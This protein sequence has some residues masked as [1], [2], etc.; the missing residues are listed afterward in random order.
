MID[1]LPN[2]KLN[3]GDLDDTLGSIALKMISQDKQV[4]LWLVIGYTVVI[5]LAILG[6]CVLNHVIM[7][8]KRVHIITGLFIVNVSV[9]KMMLALLSHDKPTMVKGELKLRKATFSNCRVCYLC[10]SL[11]F[12][13]MTGHFSRFS[14]YSCAYG[15]VMTMA[16][17]SLNIRNIT[18]ETVY[19]P[20]FPYTS[21]SMWKYLDLNTFLLFFILPLMVSVVFYGHVA[22]KLWICNAV[23]DISLHTCICQHGEKRQT[24]KI[25]MTM[26]LVYTISWLPLN[27]FLVLLCKE[28][29]SSHSALYFSHWLAISSSCYNPYIHVWL[30]NSFWIEVQKVIMEIQKTLLNELLTD[31]GA[32]LTDGGALLTELCLTH[33]PPCP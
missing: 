16:A 15:T 30:R 3:T 31:G 8:Y 10:N 20:S 5:S 26:V 13:K 18:E 25:L 22:K 32:L 17:I 24:L 2:H 28:L 7:K 27:L 11:V 9:N 23:D 21:K 29:I 6:K 1:K 19:L 33:S 12:G 4:Q 14:K